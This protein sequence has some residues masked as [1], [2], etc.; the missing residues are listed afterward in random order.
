MHHPQVLQIW[1]LKV[2]GEY[3]ICRSPAWPGSLLCL[4]RMMPQYAPLKRSEDIAVA[5]HFRR[6]PRMLVHVLDGDL[7]V[8]E[9]HGAATNAW[10]QHHFNGLVREYSTGL[11]TSQEALV[12]AM[13]YEPAPSE[14][15]VAVGG[16][17]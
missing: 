4:K 2:A 14:E 16:E 11:T 12:Q 1:V 7:Y 8:Y 13:G 5:Q 10:D 9:H 3:H 15:S 17:G 6:Q